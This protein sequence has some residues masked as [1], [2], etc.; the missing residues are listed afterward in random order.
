M[1]L[2]P[3]PSE[4][5]PGEVPFTVELHLAL[6]R[7]YE[8]AIHANIRF[9]ERWGL[10]PQQYNVIRIL[11]FAEPEGLR[12]ADILGR[13]LQRLPD[14]SRLVDRLESAG[15]ARRSPHL[16]DRRVVRVALTD[17]GRRLLAEMDPHLMAAHEQWYAALTSTEQRQLESLLRKATTSIQSAVEDA[18]ASALSAA[19]QQHTTASRRGGKRDGPPEPGRQ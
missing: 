17:Q 5:H 19:D 1:S 8:A 18:R 9:Y 4:E 2:A 6:I 15:L 11:Y 13:L 16:Q 12:L 10:T 7:A 3:R 14:V